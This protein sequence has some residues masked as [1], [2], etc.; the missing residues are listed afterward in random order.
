MNLI[1]A[2]QT[3][4]SALMLDGKTALE[5]CDRAELRTECF[6]SRRNRILFRCCEKLLRSGKESTV[7]DVAERLRAV[8]QL[9]AVGGYAYLTEASAMI[10]SRP[11][12]SR[13]IGVVVTQREFK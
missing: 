13:A 12:I 4:L 2:E 5:Q 7:C 9:D 1:E 3:V 8:G 11:D 6:S 10:P